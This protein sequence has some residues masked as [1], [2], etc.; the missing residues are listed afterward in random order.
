MFRLT[1][2]LS[3]RRVLVEALVEVSDSRNKQL[4]F[5]LPHDGAPEESSSGIRLRGDAAPPQRFGCLCHD[6][7]PPAK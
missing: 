6:Q 3:R 4:G 5:S 1:A 7:P 2:E